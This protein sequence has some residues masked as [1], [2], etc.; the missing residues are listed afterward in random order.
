MP[1]F[2]PKYAAV[3]SARDLCGRGFAGVTAEQV[4]HLAVELAPAEHCRAAG[5]P[6]RLEP[7]LM[8]VRSERDHRELLAARGTQPRHGLAR[9][10]TQRQIKDH[11]PNR[12]L[13][14][15]T[16]KARDRRF[17]G[18]DRTHVNADP[19]RSAAKAR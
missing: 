13:F 15:L 12:R 9:V 5:V 2:A 18:G 17:D 1:A 10:N 14:G 8:N 4:V 7:F 11:Q 16:F 3:T 19:C 6:R